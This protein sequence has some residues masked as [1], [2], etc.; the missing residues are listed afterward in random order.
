MV[1]GAVLC[2]AVAGWA[3]PASAAE[4]VEPSGSP[5]PAAAQLSPH[6]VSGSVGS[7]G[8]YAVGGGLVV[9]A[10]GAATWLRRK[11]AGKVTIH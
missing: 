4:G 7:A 11:R 2:L 10:G 5:D 3:T 8:V 9:V 1:S 6:P